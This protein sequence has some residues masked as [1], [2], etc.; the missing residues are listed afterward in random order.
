M[1]RDKILP[2]YSLEELNNKKLPELKKICEEHNIH[3]GNF[4]KSKK[5]YFV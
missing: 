3:K 1:N 2:K 5:V 4:Q